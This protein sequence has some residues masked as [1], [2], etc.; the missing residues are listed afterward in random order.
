MS[1]NE[2]VTEREPAPSRSRHARVAMS[3]AWGALLLTTLARVYLLFVLTLVATAGL[4]AVLSWNTYIVRSGSMSPGIKTGDVVLA[5]PLSPDEDVTAG[6]VFTFVDPAKTSP[7]APDKVLVHRVVEENDDGTFMTAGDANREHDSTPVPRAAF[8]GRGRLLVPLIG[9]PSLWIATGN[10]RSLALLVIVSVAAMA[11]GIPAGPRRRQR[12]AQPARGAVRLLPRIVGGTTIAVALSCG[13]LALAAAAFSGSTSNA[14]D[15]WTLAS[16]ID[17][18]PP[19]VDISFPAVNAAQNATGWNAGCASTICGS[20]ADSRAGLA[21]VGVSIR[22]GTAN[23]WNGSSFASASEVLHAATGTTTWSYPFAASK[24]PAD[25]YYTLRVV[26][27]DRALSANTTSASR[28]FIYDST[29]PSGGSVS[30]TDGYA[31]AA[32]V[33]ITLATGGDTG[34]GVNTAAAQVQRSSATLSAGVCGGFTAFDRLGPANPSSPLIDSS[35]VSGNCYR[36]QYLVPDNVGNVAAYTSSAVARIDTSG[37]TFGSPALSLTA[38]ANTF[39]SGTNAFYNPNVS[40]AFTVTAPNVADPQS[41]ISKVNFPTV[42]G[43]VSGG[44]DQIGPTYTATYGAAAGA[45]ASGSRTV[46]ATNGALVTAT[47]GFTLTPDGLAPGGAALAV[48]GG[49][50][51]STGSSTY[52][53][54]GTFSISRTDFTDGGAGLASSTL[55]R[56]TATLAGNSCGAFVSPT[57]L[58]GGPAQTLPTGCYRYVLTGVDNVGNAG[59]LATVVMIDTTVPT[60]PALSFS[61][62]TNAFYNSPGTTLY[63]R[64]AAGGTFTV[65]AAAGDAETG[66]KAGTAGYAFG[67]LNSNGGTNFSNTQTAGANA[68][69]FNASST[70]PAG[71]ATVSAVNNAGAISAT[72]SYSVVIDAA[73][74]VAPTPTVTASYYTSASVPVSV[75]AATDSGSGVNAAIIQRDQAALAGAACGSFP[76]TFGSSILLSGGNDTTV[77]SGFCYQYRLR[78]SDNV[79]NQA[80]SGLSG[81]AKVDTSPPSTPAL[82]FSVLTNVGAS[83][84]TV[85]ARSSQNAG[86]FTITASST[87]AETGV[88]FTFP[89]A[90][91]GWTV[92]GAGGSRTYA[93]SSPNAVMPSGSQTVTVTNGAGLVATGSF[94]V[95]ADNTGPSVADVALANGGTTGLIDQGDS[96]TITFSEQMDA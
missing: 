41:A 62:L 76:G 77:T 75:A 55:T 57:M 5:A 44:G 46:T 71:A 86:S 60:M 61:I 24:F 21:S 92:T 35:P 6:H 48:N 93:W 88:A 25:G 28:T 42:G 31:A 8:L 79:G 91:A 4:P 47:T 87:D 33:S 85:Y 23:Y 12:R 53:T 19:T 64:P 66:I 14:A 3:A 54:S 84:T 32:S 37:P 30:Y 36:Y 89:A 78:V 68:Y 51:T 16:L 59:S 67:S 10:Y 17:I 11:F 50:A 40:G 43:G 95:L 26:A 2:A 73:A 22:Q 27:T 63:L 29:A 52:S 90:P 70:A 56:S 9:S 96:A 1:A 82:S 34:S 58:T 45:G 74:P 80:T 13:V 38:G 81:V 83:G 49:G 72:V 94:S 15:R 7:F 20:A 69:T 65:T 39:I 18:T